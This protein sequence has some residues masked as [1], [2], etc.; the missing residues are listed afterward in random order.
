MGKVAVAGRRGEPAAEDAT[1]CAIRVAIFKPGCWA[2]CK[3]QAGMCGAA[4]CD[5]MGIFDAEDNQLCSFGPEFRAVHEPVTEV[6]PIGGLVVYKIPNAQRQT[7]DA[8]LRAVNELLNRK[9]A[10]FWGSAEAGI[11][12]LDTKEQIREAT[13]E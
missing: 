8:N 9:N 1:V 12:N 5:G 6:W 10:T 2:L 7:Q 13:N 11:P 3:C 4:D